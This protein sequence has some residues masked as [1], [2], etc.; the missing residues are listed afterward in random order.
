[1][2]QVGLVHVFDGVRLLADADRQGRQS[3]G[4]TPEPGA[5]GIQDGPVHLVESELIHAK[6]LEAPSGHLLVD[7]PVAAYFGEVPHPFEQSVGNTQAPRARRAISAAPDG[8]RRT[9][10]IEPDR[11]MMV[12]RSAAL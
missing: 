3:D 4:A 5:D 11:R 10:R 7:R 8:S 6:E 2:Q 12:S 1:M 9:S